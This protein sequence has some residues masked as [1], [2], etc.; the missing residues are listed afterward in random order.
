MRANCLDAQPDSRIM[1][2]S[3]HALGKHWK[4]VVPVG[5]VV[6]CRR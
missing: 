2:D 5:E 6:S 1:S 4:A 3:E